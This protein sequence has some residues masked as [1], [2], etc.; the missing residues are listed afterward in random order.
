MAQAQTIGFVK[1]IQDQLLAGAEFV[2]YS[3]SHDIFVND[4]TVKIP[5]AAA[6]PDILVNNATWPL[7]VVER[8]DDT[9]E[10]DL[11]E[12]SLGAIRLGESDKLTLS[13]DKR[14]SLLKA[15]MDYINARIGLD[16]LYEWASDTTARQVET[17]GTATNNIAPPTGTSTRKSLKLAD[18]Q[19]ALKILS[20]DNV[21]IG[22]QNK[23][24]CAIPADMYWDFLREEATV[25][26]NLQLNAS[27]VVLN[28]GVVARIM[29]INFVIRDA[30]VVF[31]TGKTKKA[32]GAAGATTDKWGAI[33]WNADYVC[34]AKSEPKVFLTQNDAT[35]QADVLSGY[36]RFRSVPLRT[37]QKGIVSIIQG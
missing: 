17:T 29:G 8:T 24:Y 2:N 12:Y 16:A 33:V 35:Y 27:N 3:V 7:T 21:S 19:S 11:N 10:Y 28:P 34:K 6:M 23:I 5:Q 30:T 1:T 14:A 4:K 37:D 36:A 22:D 15:H 32:V 26:N 18:L 13:Y 25:I 9:K 31:A 20:K